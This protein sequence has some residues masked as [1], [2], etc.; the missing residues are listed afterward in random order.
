MGSRDN[1]DFKN[2]SIFV[3]QARQFVGNEIVVSGVKTRKSKRTIAIFGELSR[4]LQKEKLKQKKDRL[5]WGEHYTIPDQDF[6]CRWDNGELLR[7]DYVSKKFKKIATDLQISNN[8]RFHDLRHSNATWLMEKGVHPK[9]VSEMLGHSDIQTTM[10][11]YS[12]VS[13]DMQRNAIAKIEQDIL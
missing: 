12:H 7:P 9:I 13:L 1:V 11:I 5:E 3:T 10:N 8:L 6:I 4:E 2:Q